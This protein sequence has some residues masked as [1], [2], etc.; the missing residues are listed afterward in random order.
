MVSPM[1][2]RGTISLEDDRSLTFHSTLYDGSPF[3][4]NVSPFDVQ[5]N[6]AF[7]PS[8]MTVPGF[9]FVQQEAKQADV[10]YLTLPKPNLTFGRQATVK[11]I[12]LMPRESKLA[13][14]NPEKKSPPVQV[15]QE[16]VVQAE[17]ASQE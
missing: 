6:E 14:F 4:L 2:L 9:L 3:S 13:I 10:C 16:E 1:K 8:K 17:L 12:Q 11:D 5:M 15:V 7:L